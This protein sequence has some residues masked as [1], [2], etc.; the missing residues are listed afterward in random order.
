M[1]Y[2]FA[3]TALDGAPSLYRFDW[4]SKKLFSATVDIDCDLIAI[5]FV[6]PVASCTNTLLVGKGRSVLLVEWDG[7]SDTAAVTEDIAERPRSDENM[8]DV[9]TTS[10]DGVLYMSIMPKTYCKKQCDL[11]YPD[12][13]FVYLD[14]G[15]PPKLR[16]A[17]EGGTY[18]NGI[19]FDPDSNV[20]YIADDCSSTVF[21]TERAG[22]KLSK[23]IRN[24]VP[25]PGKTR[26]VFFSKFFSTNKHD[27][28]FFLP[29]YK[30]NKLSDCDSNR[31][32]FEFLRWIEKLWCRLLYRFKVRLLTNISLPVSF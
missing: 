22:N 30:E 32:L 9:G 26:T 3:A 28:I 27:C 24:A 31:R 7:V 16:T 2:N 17:L 11:N 23:I 25:L 18:S 21:T 29:C 8:I 14:N 19:A 20:A 4:A 1:F 6:L 13:A 10:P 15:P 12:A 5:S